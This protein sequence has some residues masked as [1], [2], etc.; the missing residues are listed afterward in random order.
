MPT[1]AEAALDG[2]DR[3]LQAL[4]KVLEA[5]RCIRHWHCSGDAGM[6]VSK[7]HVFALWDVI[8]EHD[9][10]MGVKDA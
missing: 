4:R 8:E 10:I 5:A 9:A 1:W 6:V 7:P 2:K 3:E